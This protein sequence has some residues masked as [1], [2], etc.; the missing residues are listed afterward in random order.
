MRQKAVRL[1]A[2]ADSDF[3]TELG[4]QAERAGLI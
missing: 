1:M 4:E 2:V 3:Q